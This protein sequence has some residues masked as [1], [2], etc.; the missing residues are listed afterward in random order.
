KEGEATYNLIDGYGRNRWGDYSLCSLDP[1]KQ[2]LW[3]V[4]EYAHSHNESGENRWGTWIGELSFNLP[5]DAPK[6]TGPTGGAV[7][8]EYGFTFLSANPENEM[9]YYYIDWGDGEI[10]EWIGPFGSGEEAIVNHTWTSSGDYEIRAKAKDT[11][12]V[13]SE[14]SDVYPVTIVE[15]EPPNIPDIDGTTSGKIGTLYTYIFKS[16]D[17]DEDDLYY[18]INWDDGNIEEWIGPYNS[19]ED[20]VVSHTWSEKGTYTIKAKVK[21]DYDMESDWGTLTVSMPRN[22][23]YSNTLLLR[24]LE[25]F[26][27]LQKTLGFLID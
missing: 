7:G 8:I 4:Q 21:D 18:Y 12:D 6:I 2:T 17:P 20:A 1:V 15:N 19:G 27:I 13:E 9:I 14:W 11:N 16:T 3:T 10:E 23:A 5:P 22:R 25:R 24:L 26:P